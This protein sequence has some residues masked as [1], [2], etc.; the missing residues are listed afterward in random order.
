[1]LGTRELL[2]EAAAL[3][4]LPSWPLVTKCWASGTSSGLEECSLVN[5]I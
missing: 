1:M 3:V 5:K 2:L 4:M